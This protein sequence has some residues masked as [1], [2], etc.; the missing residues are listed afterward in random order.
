MYT[1]C[2]IILFNTLKIYLYPGI[3]LENPKYS[4]QSYSGID[5]VLGFP[6]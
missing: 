4:Q 5:K 3:S 6:S 1:V 2:T